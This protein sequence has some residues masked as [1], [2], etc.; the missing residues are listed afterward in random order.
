MEK[1]VRAVT[2]NFA[3]E[4]ERKLFTDAAAIVLAGGN[5]PARLGTRPLPR[6]AELVALIHRLQ[7]VTG[8]VAEAVPSEYAGLAERI[9]AYHRKLARLGITPTEVNLRVHAWRAAFFVLREAEVLLIGLPMALWGILNHLVPYHAT[10]LLVRKMS[11]DEDHFATNAVFFGLPIFLVCALLQGVLVG[12]LASPL[13][14]VPYLAS[15]PL[16]G[17]V[18]LLY[19]DRSGSM[20]RRVRTFLMFL[21]HPE[22]QRRL[23]AEAANII[24]DLQR[25]E[26]RLVPA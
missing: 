25:L 22:H 12:V 19:R 5:A 13:W 21:R 24:A 7:R 26:S 2:T 15:L 17:A 18:A 23:S 3:N 1:R 8:H 11:R 10:G 14:A 20:Y 6:T 4:A 9:R 16:C